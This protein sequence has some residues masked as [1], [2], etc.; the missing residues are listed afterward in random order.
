MGTEIKTWQ[1]VDGRI[2]AISTNLKDE[3]RTEP[4]DL[5][6]W[7]A[8]NPEIIGSDIAI[9]GRQVMSKSGP[10]DLLGIDKTG[11]LVIVEIKRDK[12]PREALTQA[13]DYASDISEWA[14]EKIG[15][16]CSEY[17]GKNLIE[18]ITESFPEPEEI[19]VENL[20]INN[21]QRIMLVGFSVESS[22]E[23]MIEWLSVN[24]NVNINAVV[25][26]YVRTRSGDELLAKTTIISEE[27]ERERVK[28]KRKFQ[29]SMSDEP[30]SHEHDIL[31]KLLK[32]YL[33]KDKV[34]N[35]RIRDVL[36][37]GLLEQKILTREQLKKKL[38]KHDPSLDASKAG[39]HLATISGQLGMEKNNFLRQ[40]VAYEY[41]TY[42]WEKDNFSLREEYKDLVKEVLE[43]LQKEQSSN[44]WLQPTA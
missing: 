34:T 26:N 33:S 36:L 14:I 25:L 30:G 20:N 18:F 37:P 27:L 11:N 28:K 22:L 2:E 44:K 6:P 32:E 21:T 4:Y 19:N 31:A 29:I 7:I 24:F 38:I 13:I 40:V 10:I 41:P 12:L 5:E 17:T 16:V 39:Y 9:I 35:Q 15:E 43:E 3:G 8:S 42:T 23:R 1:I